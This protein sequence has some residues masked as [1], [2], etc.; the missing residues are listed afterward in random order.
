MSSEMLVSEEEIQKAADKAAADEAADKAAADAYA[1]DV[2]VTTGADA[3]AKVGVDLPGKALPKPEE[4]MNEGDGGGDGDKKNKKKGGGIGE[5]LSKFA[6]SVGDALTGVAEFLPN[7]IE[8]ISS[9]PKKKK[10]FFKR[11]KYYSRILWI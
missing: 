9:D 6:S 1:A 8:E 3:G 11:F 4:I 10:E 5:S 7:K 2:S